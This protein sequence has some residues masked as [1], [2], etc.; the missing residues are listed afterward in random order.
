MGEVRT[1]EIH[2]NVTTEDVPTQEIRNDPIAHRPNAIILTAPQPRGH[3]AL[4]SVG[5]PHFAD[6]N[7]APNGASPR[8]GDHPT[9]RGEKKKSPS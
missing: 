3:T 6:E 4:L 1:L 7:D 8:K 2:D 5:S 9:K